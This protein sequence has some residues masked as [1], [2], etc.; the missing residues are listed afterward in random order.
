MS[1]EEWSDSLAELEAF[2]NPFLALQGEGVQ[3]DA[4]TENSELEWHGEVKGEPENHDEWW[5]EE[6]ERD[7]LGEEED[8][9][10]EEDLP[11]EEDLPGEE[12]RDL[13]GEEDDLPGEEEADLPGEDLPQLQQQQQQQH[14]CG[15]GQC[16]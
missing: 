4:A 15:V 3:E 6:E 14:G 9:P 5:E 7:L 11:C 12:E 10:G 13:P 2:G 1:A 8:L 16:S